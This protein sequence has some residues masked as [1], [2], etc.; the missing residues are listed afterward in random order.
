MPE[1]TGGHITIQVS[2]PEH[3]GKTSLAVV[4][5][6]LLTDLGADVRLQRAD[7]QI[8]EKMNADPEDVRERLKTVRVDIMEM[9][10][11]SKK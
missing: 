8:D 1:R 2:G 6:Q 10:T 4:V 5:A 9:Q 7:P 11:Y 3:S